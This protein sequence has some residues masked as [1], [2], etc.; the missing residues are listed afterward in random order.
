MINK[1]NF[2]LSTTAG[3]LSFVMSHGQVPVSQE[4]RHHKV[5]DNGHIRLLDVQIPPGDTTQFHIHA[6]PSI[7]VVLTNAKTG[8]QVVSEEDHSA[9]PIKHYGNIW[10]E[11]FYQKPRIHRVYN[12]DE[13][14]FNVMDIE[15]TNTSFKTIDPPITEGGFTFLFEEKPVR[16]YR[17]NLLHG[18][19]VSIQPRKADVLIIQLSDSSVNPGVQV[20]VP[21][22]R[23]SGVSYLNRKGSFV[24]VLSGTTFELR[25]EGSGEGEFAFLELK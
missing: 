16:A 1:M 19:T 21:D 24:Y 14:M 25:N 13:H 2:I 4:P 11:G 8:S 18:K 17:V 7:F 20:F 15:L 22:N 10:F 23:S 3:V 6:T 12:M 5:L 9:S